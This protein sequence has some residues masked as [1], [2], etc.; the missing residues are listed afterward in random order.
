MK[1][2]IA[3]ILIV[4]AA[5]VATSS[6]SE[7]RPVKV[8]FYHTSDLHEHSTTLPRIAEFVA[9]QRKQLP[10]VLFVDT[11]DWCNKGDL[12]P[13]KTRGEAITAMMSACQYDAVIPGNHDYSFGT[14]RLAELI[15]RFSLPLVAANCVWP[16]VAKPRNAVGYRLFKLDGVTVAVI[17]TATPISTQRKDTLLKILPIAESLRD[18]LPKVESQADIIALLTHL[19]TPVDEKL[20]RALPEID[21]IFGGHDHRKFE[22]VTL[23]PGTNT[24]IQH[25][26]SGGQC[27]GELTVSWDG[28][29]IVDRSVR[30]VQMTDSL[31]ASSTVSRIRDKY[32]SGPVAEDASR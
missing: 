32:V 8:T 5:L 7:P 16:E 22:K 4:L 31:P 12:T 10:N 14:E 28:Q 9:T 6:A 21:I 29:R 1:Q 18:V 17:G 27:I 25:S 30:L 3:S 20:A 15:D 13:L 26:G 11:G 2:R 24:V 19:G 23:A